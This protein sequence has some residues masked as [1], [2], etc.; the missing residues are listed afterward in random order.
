MNLLKK[1]KKF[2]GNKRIMDRKKIN[3]LKRSKIS[4]SFNNKKMVKK[5]KK[6]TSTDYILLFIIIII[7]YYSNYN[8]QKVNILFLIC[9]VRRVII[10]MR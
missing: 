6:K 5:G 2:V 3:G 10:Y 1:I 4:L 7:C 9:A 8:N